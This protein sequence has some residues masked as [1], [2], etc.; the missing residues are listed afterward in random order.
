MT[1]EKSQSLWKLEGKVVVVP[2]GSGMLGRE[3]CKALVECGAKVA[4]LVRDPLKAQF[5]RDEMSAGHGKGILLKADVLDK[6]SLLLAREKVLGELGEIYA[7]VN[8]AGG[9]VQD[10]TTS[11]YRSFFQL[12]ESALKYAIDLNLMGTILPCQVFGSEMAEKGEGVIVNVGSMAGFRPLT[13]T[14]AYS[15]A[16]AALANF[17]QWLAVHMAMEYSPGIRVN[18]VAPGFFHTKQNHY[19]LF[20]DSTGE[21]TP[22]GKTILAHTPMRRFGTPKDL[23]GAVL[24]LLSPMSSFVTGAV[25][26]VDGG[27]SAYSGV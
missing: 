11:P 1:S 20:D 12:E 21:L 17:T 7:L 16:K 3:I 15:A 26:P 5:L 10:A 14:V 25:I 9:N 18:A 4:A 23:V 27:F 19:L 13:R 6:G 24:W 8:F 2:G 22:R